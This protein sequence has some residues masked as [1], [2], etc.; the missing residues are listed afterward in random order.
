MLLPPARCT[1]Y[2]AQFAR[3]LLRTH[4]STARQTEPSIGCRK[5]SRGLS[6]RVHAV[7]AAWVQ[8]HT[9]THI[10]FHTTM[11]SVERSHRLSACRVKVGIAGTEGNTNMCKMKISNGFRVFANADILWD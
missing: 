1:E 8:A 4:E 2:A 10:R 11:T 9:Q 3:V 6:R 5:R 7:N